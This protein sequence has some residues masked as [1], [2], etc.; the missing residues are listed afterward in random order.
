VRGGAA[1]FSA[2][3]ASKSRL[4]DAEMSNHA[5]NPVRRVPAAATRLV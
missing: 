4:S 2:S 3:L 1:R 5:E